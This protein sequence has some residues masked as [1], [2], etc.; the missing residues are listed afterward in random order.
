VDLGPTNQ[1]LN[2]NFQELTR[3]FKA[4]P[5]LANASGPVTVNL[6]PGDNPIATGI[7][8]AQGRII[9][10]QSAI[11]FL[12]DKGLDAQNRWVINASGAV[13]IIVYFF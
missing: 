3:V 13:K 12:F 7:A 10:F 6:V 4:M 11:S 1:D 2:K 5:D 9:T 8:K